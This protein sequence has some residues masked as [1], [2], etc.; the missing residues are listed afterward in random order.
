MF[1]LGHRIPFFFLQCLPINHLNNLHLHI[2]R[3][4][5]GVLLTFPVSLK[6]LHLVLSP[7]PLLSRLVADIV[8]C[9]GALLF[10]HWFNINV[11]QL[12]VTCPTDT[13]HALGRVQA[14]NTRFFCRIKKLY[15]ST[16][17]CHHDGS[18]QHGIL[19]I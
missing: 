17:G 3:D 8:L 5:I 10:L 9:L 1:S 6:N 13:V 2:A 14:L 12:D 16:P 11:L 19:G 7:S 18:A 4:A 15:I